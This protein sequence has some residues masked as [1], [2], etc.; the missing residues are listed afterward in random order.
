MN[1]RA[2]LTVADA[3]IL[4][5]SE[6]SWR[7]AVSRAYYAAFHVAQQLFHDLGFTVPRGDRAHGYLWLRLSN[8][9]NSQ[10]QIAG[11]DLKDLRGDRNWADYDLS[12]LLTQTL[13]SNQINAAKGIIRLLDNARSSIGHL[14]QIAD[15]MKIYERDVLKDVTWHP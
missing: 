10:V 14:S 8:C 9:G 6:A 11:K 4:Q 7:S 2:F 1:G 12:F 15:S 3:L 5:T 13:A